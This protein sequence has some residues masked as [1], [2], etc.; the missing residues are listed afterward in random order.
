MNFKLA[1]EIYG[2][3]WLADP[4][5]IQGLFSMLEF[6]KQGGKPDP[7]AVKANAFGL[8]DE[9]IVSS[10]NRIS[11]MEVIP[12]GTIAI[13][14]LDSVITKGGGMSS[15]GT[16]DIANQFSKME[17]EANVIGHL[18]WIESGGGSADAVKYINEVID[19]DVR[20]KPLVTYTEDIMASAAMYIASNSDWI[21]S[22]D[23]STMIG[24]IGTMIQ[25]SGYKAQSESADGERHIRAYGSRSVNK[26]NEFEAAINDFNIELLQKEV[27]DP[28]V[29]EF[30]SDME[31]N[32]P[33]I[34]EEQKTGKIY[35]ASET[36]GT[37]IDQI[38][39]FEDAVAKVKELSNLN[40]NTNTMNIQQL[41]AE[42]PSL[43]A[44]V[45]NQGATQERERLVTE[46]AKIAEFGT[47]A[48]I[49][50]IKQLRN[51]EGR[52]SEFLDSVTEEFTKSDFLKKAE[53]DSVA[54][55]ASQTPSGSAEKTDEEKQQE[56]E[57]LENEAILESVG[58]GKD[59][60]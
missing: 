39:S 57:D 15:H 19:K 7:N 30:V 5:T 21:I 18:F 25:M 41:Q 42:H 29:E 38:G 40:T 59:K 24:S 45:L 49:A 8:L 50:T 47:K 10:P 56:K 26:N 20:M 28:H 35:K 11:N 27:L 60:V 34:T 2:N 37:L 17:N 55:S 31:R 22:R 51:C 54:I 44:E 36:V 23:E 46:N 1:R 48:P 58:L 14:Y 16:V 6:Y 33:N 9:T 13:Y 52:T 3:V 12:E 43:F 32:R 53:T 4:R